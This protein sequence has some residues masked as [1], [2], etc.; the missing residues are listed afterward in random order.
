MGIFSS[1]ST[2]SFLGVDIGSTS[3]K[4]VELRK[5]A[6]QAKLLSYGFSDNKKVLPASWQNDPKY[7]AEVIKKICNEAGITSNTAVS[8]LPT[9]S[10]FTSILNLSSVSK[11]DIDSA[12]HWE[13]K[14]V[15]PLPLEE[16]I[17]NWNII[18]DGTAQLATEKDKQATIKNVKVLLTGAPKTLV[19]KYVDIFKEAKINL[20]SL[21][22]ET[23]SLVRSLVGND[24]SPVML[25]E[26]GAGTTD[27]SIINNGIP[28][29]NRSIDVG[30]IKISRAISDFS[31]I[32]LERAEQF[33]F[34]LGASA[35][36]SP[37]STTPQI[38]SESI[39]PIV[40]EIKYALN[41]FHDKYN[42]QAE[43]I[44]LSGGSALLPS[45]VDYL[46]KVLNIKVIIGDPWA[47]IS[48]PVDLA[49]LL[50]EIGPRMSVAIGLAMR[51]LE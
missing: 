37:D 27:I 51:E 32:D 5:E 22:T 14:K 10:V 21:E 49:P 3:V 17:L 2:P 44:I 45:L 46:S 1:S 36:D 11:K 9:F 35:I 50:N 23:F 40:N 39:A 30:G 24:K 43:K 34:D 18:S 48:F 4:I 19:K 12:V 42:L 28:I 41:L 13:A 38:I 33:K 26:I 31:N 20:L 8:A 29:L 16:M 6:G 25:V 15:I 47:R 7:V